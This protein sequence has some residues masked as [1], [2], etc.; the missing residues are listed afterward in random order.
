MKI[1]RVIAAVLLV[2]WL[3]PGVSAQEQNEMPKRVVS[4]HAS[5]ADAWLTAGGE[6]VGVPEN[7]FEFSEQLANG[8]AGLHGND[9]EIHCHDRTGGL[10][11]AA[12]GAGAITY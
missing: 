9:A 10:V 7:A 11:S 8:L 1:I 2:L 5:Y 3:V 12:G 4:L 6:L